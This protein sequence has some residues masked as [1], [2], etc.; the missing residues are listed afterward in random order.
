M[1]DNFRHFTLGP[2]PAGRIWQVDFLWLQTAVAIRHSDSVDVK[3]LLT[4]GDAR[5]EKVVSLRHPDL[6]DLSRTAGRPP[7]DSWCMTLAARH[8]AKMIET[9]ADFEKAL[10]T[11]DAAELAQYS[12]MAGS[13][14]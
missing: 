13:R 9:G 4:S 10:A 3:F 5:I 2:D 6:V 12:A 14:P 7:T 1:T 11:V 8:L